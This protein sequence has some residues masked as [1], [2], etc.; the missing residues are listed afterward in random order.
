MKNQFAVSPLG[1]CIVN[2]MDGEMSPRQEGPKLLTA[3]MK[4][5]TPSWCPKYD[6]DQDYGIDPNLM[7]TRPEGAHLTPPSPLDQVPESVWGLQQTEEIAK[8]LKQQREAAAR[9]QEPPPVPS[10]KL[11]P[12]GHE[13]ANEDPQAD[14]PIPETRPKRKNF[15][16]ITYERSPTK[17]PNN[18]REQLGQRPTLVRSPWSPWIP[19]QEPENNVT[20]DKSTYKQHLIDQLRL[21]DAHQ[22]EKGPQTDE[23]GSTD[24]SEDQE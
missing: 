7:P 13:N 14:V 19:G 6:L 4:K 23:L 16:K 2:V 20:W 1:T 24:E 8:G 12:T 15:K 11:S 21:L 10:P 22:E 5:G 9:D 3:A 18:I 17:T